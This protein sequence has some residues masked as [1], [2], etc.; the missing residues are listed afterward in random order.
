MLQKT[1]KK[2][3]YY[4]KLKNHPFQIFPMIVFA[5]ILHDL[6]FKWYWFETKIK[7]LI[8]G[9]LIVVGLLYEKGYLLGGPLF[10]YVN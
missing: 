7:Q 2:D 8:F 9:L 6:F 10:F 5:I 3:Y 1:A 4:N